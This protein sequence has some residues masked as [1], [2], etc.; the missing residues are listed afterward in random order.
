M[1]PT[2]KH[3]VSVDLA[4]ELAAGAGMP[5]ADAVKPEVRSGS[6]FS[7][8]T[9]AG[10][11]KTFLVTWFYRVQD[12]LKFLDAV[13]NFEANGPMPDA[14]T[15]PGLTYLGTYSVTISGAVP[16][17]EYRTMWGLTDLGKIQSLN[18]YLQLASRATHENLKALLGFI[19]SNPVMRSEIMGYTRLSQRLN[20]GGLPPP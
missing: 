10:D 8:S 16:D 13:S 14:T 2:S 4:A 7:F 11:P 9:G 1:G 12:P 6:T 17:F 19:S 5:R 3:S 20:S 18:A 15:S